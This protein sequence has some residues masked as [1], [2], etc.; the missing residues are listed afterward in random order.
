MRKRLRLVPLAAAAA[1][2]AAEG[3]RVSYVAPDAQGRIDV[4]TFL[5]ACDAGTVVAS[6]MLVNNETGVRQPV[7]DLAAGLGGEPEQGRLLLIAGGDEEQ[8]VGILGQGVVPVHQRLGQLALD[9]AGEDVRAPLGDQGRR[10]V[11]GLVLGGVGVMGRRTV[12]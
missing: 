9:Q 1:A 3:F 10:R 5:A 6:L 12:K 4:D 7:A 8:M 11:M 2:L